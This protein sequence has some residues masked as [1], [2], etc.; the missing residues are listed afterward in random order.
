MFAQPAVARPRHLQIFISIPVRNTP[1][2]SVDKGRA[3]AIP[4]ENERVRFFGEPMKGAEPRHLIFY[5]RALAKRNA[6]K[7]P[8]PAVPRSGPVN[9]ARLS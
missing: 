5:R 6:A 7:A 4:G 2:G 9:Q 8:K 1:F 3:N